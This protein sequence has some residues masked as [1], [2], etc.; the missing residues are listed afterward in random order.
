MGNGKKCNACANNFLEYSPFLKAWV[1]SCDQAKCKFVTKKDKGLN[2][3]PR[4]R[5]REK[6]LIG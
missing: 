5:K 6:E 4:D 3:R 1:F 2:V